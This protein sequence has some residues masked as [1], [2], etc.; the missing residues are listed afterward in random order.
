MSIFSKQFSTLIK[1]DHL[2][3]DAFLLDFP[4]AYSRANTLDTD[5]MTE[6]SIVSPEYM[7]L[8]YL[9][10]RQTMGSMECEKKRL[11]Y[12]DFHE[13]GW[14]QRVHMFFSSTY[15]FNSAVSPAA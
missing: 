8:V 7:D 10:L 1:V 13:G 11:G 2:Q 15:L 6:A 9:G 5:I 14:R 12:Q 3:I 4:N